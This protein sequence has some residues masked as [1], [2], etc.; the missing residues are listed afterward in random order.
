ME[1]LRTEE[2]VS[3]AVWAEKYLN[4]AVG[5]LYE[6]GTFPE[7]GYFRNKALGKEVCMVEMN[8]GAAII[9]QMVSDT[10]TDFKLRSE[11]NEEEIAQWMEEVE[12][13]S[14]MEDAARQFFATGFTAIQL[15]LS[16]DGEIIPITIESTRY[17]PDVPK[18]VHMAPREVRVMTPFEREEKNG[19]VNYLFVETHQPGVI[20]NEVFRVDDENALEGEKVALSKFEDFAEIEE[21]VATGLDFIPIFQ[22][23]RRK[24]GSKFFGE[25]SLRPV[26][27]LLQQASEIQ[28]A[29]RNEMVKHG[30]AKFYGNTQNMVKTAQN[31]PCGCYAPDCAT[32]SACSNAQRFDMNM[33]VMNVNP[34]DPIPGYMTRDLQ[35][36][37]KGLSQMDELLRK[38]SAIIGS[39]SSIFNVEDMSGNTRVETDRRKER[40]YSKN[41]MRAQQRMEKLANNLIRSYLLWSGKED[42]E[43]DLKFDS[44]FELTQTEKCEL[45][46]KL[47]TTDKLISQKAAIELVFSDRT[48]EERDEILSELETQQGEEF[49][50]LDAFNVSL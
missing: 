26:W 3:R 37:D 21:M 29:M 42:Q 8:A 43:V 6:S 48:P 39:P 12:F 15:T 22:A 17:F 7:H 35:F 44:P 34:G 1:V 10:I 20:L 46:R 16:E 31:N 24:L 49:A 38:V 14:I 9:D 23:N 13:D 33:E 18:L 50:R 47:N 30:A 45:V 4:V 2:E 41:I 25:S 32:C 40:K 27:S 36:L 19:I 11:G 28:T 5:D